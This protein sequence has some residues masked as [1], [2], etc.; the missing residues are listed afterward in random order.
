MKM[1][2]AIYLI[3]FLTASC[4]S[5][6][7]QFELYDKDEGVREKLNG[8]NYTY[9]TKTFLVKNY[10]DNN[11][12]EIQID[13][14]V[15][16]QKN[17]LKQIDNINLFFYKISDKTNSANWEKNPRDIDRYSNEHDII[18]NY[19]ISKSIDSTK[20]ISKFKYRNGKIK[21]QTGSIVI[22]DAPKKTK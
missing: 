3:F 21:G 17:T 16:S 11:N 6:S 9:V 14:F 2:L 19:V 20:S 7:L 8:S 1:N 15:N 5:K 18:Y 4:A 12:S 22:Q 10:S 13:S